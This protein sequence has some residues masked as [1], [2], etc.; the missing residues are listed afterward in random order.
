MELPQA[1][2][3]HHLQ[4]STHISDDVITAGIANRK[5][6][7]EA[8]GFHGAE[9][10]E[11]RWIIQQGAINS[12]SARLW[13]FPTKHWAAQ[14]SAGRL[15]KPEALE[16]GDQIRTTA[17]VEYSTPM[18]GGSWSSSLIWGRVHDTGTGHN[19][20]SYLAESELPI[21]SKNFITGR[22]ELVD[23]D[24]LFELMDLRH[25]QAR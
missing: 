7:L 16:P 8:S 1:T 2:L 23:K 6:K 13:Y 4:N 21:R 5:F 15:T 12:W 11:D 22:I 10:G 9:P 18:P 14:V 20:N 17:F 24:E 19:L 25:F 3:S